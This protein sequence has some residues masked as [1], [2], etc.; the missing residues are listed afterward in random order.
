MVSQQERTRL[1]EAY[2]YEP[3]AGAQVMLRYA[4][5]LLRWFGGVWTWIRIIGR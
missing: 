2:K 1:I 5:G 4:T 3:T